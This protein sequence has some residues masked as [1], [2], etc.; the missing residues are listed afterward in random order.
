MTDESTLSRSKDKGY[1]SDLA[2]QAKPEAA[3]AQATMTFAPDGLPQIELLPAVGRNRPPVEASTLRGDARRT[4]EYLA[5]RGPTPVE[6]LHNLARLSFAE[7]IVEIRTH[8][9][10]TEL[11]AATFWKECNLALLPYTAPRFDT[12]DLGAALAGGGAGG[13]AVAHFL[14]ASLVAERFGNPTRDLSTT[15]QLVDSSES[16]GIGCDQGSVTDGLQAGAPARALPPKP[17]D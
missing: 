10:C 8:A 13:L 15:Q 14:A 12:L 6:A 5:L 1:P 3:P 17:D 9:K 2:Q 7:A 11:Q 16:R 4:S